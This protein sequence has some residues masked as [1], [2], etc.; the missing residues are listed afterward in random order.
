M[1]EKHLALSERAGRLNPIDRAAEEV[2]LAGNVA[3][4]YLATGLL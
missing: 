2:E 3:T 1:Q 4:G